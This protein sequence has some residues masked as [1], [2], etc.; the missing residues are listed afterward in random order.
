MGILIIAILIGLLP[1]AI[2]SS[3]GRS[4]FLWWIYGA[5]IWIVAF[6][7]SLLLKPNRDELDHRAITSGLKKCPHCAEMIRE[8]ARVCRYCQRD[9][10]IA[11]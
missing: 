6:P 8:E 9:Q 1:A 7:H 5:A 11:A 3:K 10:A 2:A 4:F